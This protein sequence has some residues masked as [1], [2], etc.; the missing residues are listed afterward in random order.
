M[1]EFENHDVNLSLAVET[2]QTGN[3]VIGEWLRDS[4]SCIHH[5]TIFGVVSPIPREA[6]VD[7]G[8]I[9]DSLGGTPLENEVSIYSMHLQG[10]IS[11]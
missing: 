3:N 7:L 9:Y 4:N 11:R 2:D 5:G 10:M 8:N 6:A 1:H